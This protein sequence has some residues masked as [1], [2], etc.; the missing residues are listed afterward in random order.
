MARKSRKAPAQNVGNTPNTSTAE[1]S[2]ALY[3]RISVDTERKR[4][5]DTIGTQIQLLQDYVSQHPDIHVYDTYADNNFSGTNFIRPEF[6]RMM[7][8]IRAGK[9]NCVIVKDLSRL[10]RNMLESGDFIEQVFPQLGIRFIAV[11]DC[12]DTLT[13]TPDI[14]V[15]I[16]NYANELYAR[17]IAKKITSVKRNQ[18]MAGQY[19][20]GIAPYGYMLDPNVKGH[21]IPNPD[22]APIVLEIYRLFADGNT[23]RFVAKT[24]NEQRVPSPGNYR[25]LM[26]QQKSD[27][28]KKSLWYMSTVKSILTNPIYIGWIVANKHHS[29]YLTTGSKK[30]VSVPE[31]E[32]IV[33]KSMHEPIVSTALYEKVQGIFEARKE[34]YALVA[35]TDCAGQ[36]ANIFK[37]ILKCGECGRGMY[38][39]RKGNNGTYYICSIHEGYGTEYCPKKGVKMDHVESVALTLIRNQIRLFSDAKELVQMLNRSKSACTRFSIISS[40]L[41]DTQAKIDKL[42][43]LKA[44]LYEDLT[45]GI[46]T[47]EDYQELSADYSTQMDELRIFISELEKSKAQYDA[48]FGDNMVWSKLIEEYKNADAIDEKMAAAFLETMTL[49][50]DGHVEVVFKYRDELDQVISAAAVRSKEAEKYV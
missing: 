45:K 23:M 32:W 26:G 17:D 3:A 38:I 27:R 21:L 40:Q 44:S 41:K 13:D 43:S 18:Q 11:T 1:Y 5:A 15:Q 12:F 6:S 20:A 29:G 48:E 9:V 4:E 39:R 46:I 37:G 30:I 7:T 10:G 24:L 47:R 25:Y 34:E 35:T 36:R 42:S 8:D 2:A 50:N 14:S 49:Y 16:R 22:T 33:R 28:F 31:E 19:T